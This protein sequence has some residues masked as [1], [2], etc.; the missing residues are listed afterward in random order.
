[1]DV[2]A[3]HLADQLGATGEVAP[4]VR[5]AGLQHAAVVAEQLQVVHALQDLVAELR[6][7]DAL[8]GIQAGGNG[9]LAEHGADAVVL[10]DL[11]QEVDG[12][13]GRGPV[14]VVDHACG[15]VAL[16]A[17]EAADLG[18]QVAH[19]L[20]HG[21]LGVQGPFGRRPRITDQPGGAAHESQRLVAGQLEPAHQE[22]LDQVAQVQARRGGIEAA[23]IRDGVAGEELFQLRLVG[24]DV[25]KAAPLQLLPDI[26]E[27]GVVLLGSRS[28]SWDTNLS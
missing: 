19:P 5:A 18:L 21:V 6:V 28:L 20:G 4:L 1:M 3:L 10:A 23:V 11:A 12:A 9:V 27:A 13:Q 25:D 22:Q 17:Q 16:E 26:G 8:V 14:E 2:L 24:G 15:I 7:A